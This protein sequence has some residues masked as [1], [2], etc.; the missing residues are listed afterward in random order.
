MKWFGRARRGP[1][2]TTTRTV[3]RRRR[4]PMQGYYQQLIYTTSCAGLTL[5]LRFD[6][7]VL[8]HGSG[9]GGGS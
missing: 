6:I 9:G 7:V 1:S 2:A 5:G 4:L 8:V 3:Q